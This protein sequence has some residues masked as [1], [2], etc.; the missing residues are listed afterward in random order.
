MRGEGSPPTFN[1]SEHGFGV[2][3]RL[4]TPPDHE[5]GLPGIRTW[6]AVYIL[7]MGIFVLWVVLLTW[8]TLH[9]S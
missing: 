4:M 9:Y 8:L 7:V 6:R 1:R 3:F 5:T 2:C